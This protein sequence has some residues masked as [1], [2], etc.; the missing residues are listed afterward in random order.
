MAVGAGTVV[1]GSVVYAGVRI[2]AGCIVRDSV[3]GPRAR[4]GSDS[5]LVGAAVGDGAHLGRRC[6]LVAGARVGCEVR[7]PD[8]GLRF[9]G[10]PGDTAVGNPGATTE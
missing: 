6:E 7:L 10:D 9:S 8:A 3:V 4:I 2:G 5:T 1:W